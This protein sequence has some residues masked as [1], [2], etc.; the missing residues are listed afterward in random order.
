MSPSSAFCAA[1]IHFV[2]DG[3]T[4]AA[5]RLFHSNRQPQYQIKSFGGLTISSGLSKPLGDCLFQKVPIVAVLRKFFTG[6]VAAVILPMLAGEA[7]LAEVR[8]EILLNA[9][10]NEA[11]TFYASFSAN[12]R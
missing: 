8:F 2:F 7:Q 6:C 12:R 4:W 5:K 11:L 10:M 9:L 3:G 1:E